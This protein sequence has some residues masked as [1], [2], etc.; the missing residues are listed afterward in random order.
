MCVDLLSFSYVSFLCLLI[1]PI[2]YS[3]FCMSYHP[4]SHTCKARISAS[5]ASWFCSK[6]CHLP[7]K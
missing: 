7:S 5:N 1:L 3:V 6:L 4:F 2:V